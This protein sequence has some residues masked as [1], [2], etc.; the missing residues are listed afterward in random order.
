VSGVKYSETRRQI[1]HMAMGLIALLLP[2]LTWPQAA[3]LALAALLFN[4][5]ALARVLPGIIRPA[6]AGGHRAGVLFYPLSVLLLILVFRGRLDLAAA[7]WGV[8]AFGD[9]ASTIA[10][11]RLGGPPLPWNPEKT[12][13]GFAAFVLAGSVSSFALVL[14]MTPVV[15]SFAAVIAATIVAAFVETI[16]IK[17][18]DNLSVPFA[19]GATLS[20]LAVSDPGTIDARTLSIWPWA[21]GVNVVMALAVWMRGS[22]T[23]T[24]AAVGTVLGTVIYLARGPSSWALLFISFALAAL[25]SRIGKRRKEALGI[26]EDRDGKRG[27]GNTIANCLVGAIGAWLMLMA[28]GALIGPVM[29]IAGL[30]AGA[31][32]TVA[33]EIGKAYGGTPRAF[34]SF[35]AVPPGTPGAISIVGTAAGFL[36]AIAMAIAGDYLIG[37]NSALWVVIGATLGAFVESALA[38]R[39]ESQGILNNDVLN[40]INTAVAATVAVLASQAIAGHV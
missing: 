17:L 36:T 34:P 4:F 32:D 20:V 5:F 38:T 19:A 31:S 12:W 8:M 29:L 10:G 40:F 2:F 26:A 13:S 1:V 15:L 14:W 3:L 11:K 25:T 18:D 37:L 7:A 33:S 30:V 28:P 27:A 22:L 16:P 24:G 39:Y 35:K 9:G 6:D 21:I 23:L